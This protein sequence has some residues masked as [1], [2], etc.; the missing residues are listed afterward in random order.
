MNV[1]T[2]QL[3]QAALFLALGLIVPYIFHTTGIA[4]Q[5]FLPMHLPVLLCGFILGERY[6][7][8]VGFITPILNSVLTGMP[9][10]YP[11]ALAMALELASYGFVAGY[12]YK[13]KKKNVILSLITA[14]IAG[15]IVLGVA[16]YVLFFMAGNKYLLTMFIASS[17]IKPIWGIIIQLVLIPVIIKLIENRKEI[18]V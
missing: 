10:I 18:N 4:G 17:F 11:T 5:I 6:G 7:I 2:N 14:M 16:N 8:I 1:K 13:N 12:I 9:P 15:R 3:V